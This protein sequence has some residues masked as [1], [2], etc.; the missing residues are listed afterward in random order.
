MSDETERTS[1]A[2]QC[3]RRVAKFARTT[4]VQTV[5]DGT[6]GKKKCRQPCRQALT[7]N[8]KTTCNPLTALTAFFVAAAHNAEDDGGDGPNF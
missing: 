6:D 7:A 2:G 5:A 1:S 8:I 3:H 4:W